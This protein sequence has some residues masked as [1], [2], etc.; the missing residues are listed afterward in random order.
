[1]KLVSALHYENREGLMN[2]SKTPQLMQL[3]SSQMRFMAARQ[4]VL[5]Q[6]ISHL[7]TPG[8]QAQDLKK[9]SFADMVQ[10][11]AAASSEKRAAS[12]L[13]TTSPKHISA[14]T[15]M[16]ASPY[17]VETLRKPYEMTPSGNG[18]VLEEQ[19]AKISETGANYE[20]VSAL[21]RK[22]GQ[23]YRAALGQR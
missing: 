22:F 8:Y 2:D 21:Y 15:G 13:A 12:T 6:N 4:K 5:A 20:M 7:D 1:M 14:V 17:A 19:M 9:P 11:S 16:D 3:L 23:M 18:V 10:Q